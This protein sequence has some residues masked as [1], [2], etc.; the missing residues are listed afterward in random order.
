MDWHYFGTGHEKGPHDG[1]GACLKQTLRKEQLRPS[2]TQ[3]CGAGDVVR[4][5]EEAMDLPNTTY[6]EARR[7]VDR[8]FKLIGE[9]EVAREQERNCKTVYGSRSLHLVRSVNHLNNFLLEAREFS[10]FCPQCVTGTGGNCL[11]GSHASPW[12]LITLE[13]VN[14]DDVLQEFGDAD[15]EWPSVVD[16]NI[17]ASELVVGDNFA[18]FAEPR[19]SEGV[20]FLS[21]NVPDQYTQCR[22]IGE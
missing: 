15:Q 22:R 3:L 9:F 4:F 6:L 21:S 5:L 12:Q 1:A 19:N 13:P 16:D 7:L 18:V 20:D 2:S 8:H 14:S 11:K 17:Y 10:C